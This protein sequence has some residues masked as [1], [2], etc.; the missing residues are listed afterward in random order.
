M[1]ARATIELVEGA[2]QELHFAV[3]R[4]EEYVLELRV[5]SDRPWEEVEA[6]LIVPEEAARRGEETTLDVSWAVD[7]QPGRTME[8]TGVP[9]WMPG[10]CRHS[11]TVGRFEARARERLVLHFEVTRAAGALADDTAMLMARACPGVRK[12]TIV[13]NMVVGAILLGL[14]WTGLVTVGVG[15]LFTLRPRH[16][17]AGSGEA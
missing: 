5:K 4:D 17:E 9:R 13:A 12:E 11:V 10:P 6:D 7:P 1:H 16:D 3:D 2:T 8:P 15:A 14:V